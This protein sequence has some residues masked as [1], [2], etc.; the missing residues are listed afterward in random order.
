MRK[1]DFRDLQI[2]HKSKAL[3]PVLYKLTKSFPD[4]E[5]FGV[6]SQIR[7]AA[8]SVSL[9]I[10]EGHGRSSNA[11]FVRFLYMSLGSIRELEA[12]LEISV[13]LDFISNC[14]EYIGRLQELAKMITSL[15]NRLKADS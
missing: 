3:C 7:R 13:E 6:V 8:L 10:A 14:S 15:I 2:W 11:D 1:S 5:K 9:N 4:E 12:L